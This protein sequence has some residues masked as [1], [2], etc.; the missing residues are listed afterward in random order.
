MPQLLADGFPKQASRSRFD[1][2]EWADGKVWRFLRGED[3]TSSTDSFRY[4]LKRWGKANGWNVEV[5]TI[6]AVDDGGRALPATK[7]EPIGVAARFTQPS[8]KDGG[9]RADATRLREASA[10]AA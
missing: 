9:E 2:T 1:F 7:A 4:N 5:Q 3:Y 10:R 6:P 8:A